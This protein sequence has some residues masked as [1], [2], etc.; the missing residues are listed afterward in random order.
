MWDSEMYVLPAVLLFHPLTYRSVLRYR[1]GTAAE[2]QHNAER[3]GAKGYHYAWESAAAGTEVSSASVDCPECEWRKFHVSGAVA[4]AIRQ[5]YS[6]TMDDEYSTSLFYYGCDLSREIA[7]F[8]AD[9]AVYDLKTT[10]YDIK[11]ELS[12][13]EYSIQCYKLFSCLD[14]TGPDETFT[15]INNNPYTLVL[16]SLAIH[17]ARYYSCICNRNSRDEIPDEWVHK[18][19]LFNLPFNN[20]KRQH[21]PYEGF[22]PNSG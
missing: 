3:F 1:S 14:I 4:W 15:N 6:A 18:A 17:W 19:T 10:R 2:A 7:R 16:A 11:S 12:Y 13:H 22:N 9:R 5:Y 21:Y 8:F 20:I